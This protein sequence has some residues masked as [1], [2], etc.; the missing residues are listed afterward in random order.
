M[1]R[2]P[3]CCFV[4]L[5]QV[6]DLKDRLRRTKGLS[7]GDIHLIDAVLG[8]G[9]VASRSCDLFGNSSI[10]SKLV[11]M[12]KVSCIG[13]VLVA[14]LWCGGTSCAWDC[15]FVA[16]GLKGVDNVYTQ[17]E[18]LL[19][20]TLDVRSRTVFVLLLWQLSRAGACPFAATLP[21][22]AEQELVS[23][24]WCRST[25]WKSFNSCGIHYWRLH[26]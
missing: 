22:Q 13:F 6:E 24:R 16:Q 3:M 19:S 21:W 20:Q 2:V 5:M 23:R 10:M 14:P 25:P 11:S 15:V 18:P 17:H 26:V 4:L 7:S 12:K 9:G 8:Y 1:V